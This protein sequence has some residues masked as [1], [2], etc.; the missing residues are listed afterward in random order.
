M[1]MQIKKQDKI[2]AK[3]HADINSPARQSSGTDRLANVRAKFEPSSNGVNNVLHVYLL[4]I[5]VS[6]SPSSSSESDS[7]DLSRLGNFT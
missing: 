7:L 4:A 1:L 3:L 5:E 6:S 2:S